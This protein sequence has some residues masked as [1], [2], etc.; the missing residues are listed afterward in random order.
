MDERTKQKTLN[1]LDSHT[2][3][4]AEILKREI[5][6]AEIKDA[7]KS[8]FEKR[9]RVNFASEVGEIVNDNT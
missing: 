4:L 9:F 6:P 7:V 2:V 3:T 5:E 1:D 8:G